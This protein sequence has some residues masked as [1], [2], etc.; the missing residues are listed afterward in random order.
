MGLIIALLAVAVIVLLIH[1]WSLS[2][3]I[4]A[5]LLWLM[6]KNLPQPSD[7]ELRKFTRKAAAHQIEDLKTLFCSKKS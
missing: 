5:I 1:S 3:G 2:T 7:A 4:Q 6:D